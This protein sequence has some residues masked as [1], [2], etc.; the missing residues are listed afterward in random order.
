MPQQGGPAD[1]SG[2]AEFKETMGKAGDTLSTGPGT[3]NYRERK[4]YKAS[5]STSASGPSV[6]SSAKQ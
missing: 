4:K 5:D 3:T 2:Y 6:D 1:T